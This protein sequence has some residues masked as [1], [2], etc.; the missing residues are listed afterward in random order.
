MVAAC[1]CEKAEFGGTQRGEII[2][3][4]GKVDIA[5]VAPHGD[6]PVG[7][8]IAV[9]FISRIKQGFEPRERGVHV[10]I[11]DRVSRAVTRGMNGGQDDCNVELLGGPC[12]C[13]QHAGAIMSDLR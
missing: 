2:R 5:Q 6:A 11:T 12:S 1:R 3:A 7:L 8:P 9:D 13:W 10:G 4:T